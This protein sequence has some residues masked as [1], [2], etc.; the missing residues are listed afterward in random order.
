MGCNLSQQNA[1]KEKVLDLLNRFEQQII[2]NE[3]MVK[4]LES[5]TPEDSVV[6]ESMKEFITSQQK[7]LSHNRDLL[8]S[9]R[10]SFKR[11]F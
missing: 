2:L 7:S 6:T 10:R 8:I 4:E 1:R 3:V 9:F 11:R 5:L